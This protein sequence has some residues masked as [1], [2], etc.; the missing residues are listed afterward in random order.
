HVVFVPANDSEHC[1]QALQQLSVETWCGRFLGGM[2][3]WLRTH[4]PRFDTVMVCRHYVA[5]EMLP[6]VRRYAPQARLVFDTV[7]LH[8]LR[9]QRAAEVSGDAAAERTARTTRT[10]ELDIVARSD[11]TL[12]VSEV[13]REL[14]PT[15][16]PD[17]AV[18]IIS[19][20]HEPVPGGR[21]FNER[22]G[23]LFVGGF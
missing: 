19:N 14:L 17:A 11:V 10:L 3:G 13:E 6:L 4:G 18:E 12:V 22:A 20:L 2:P 9:E 8:Y 5:R 15:E 23:I 21:D 16:V 7:D 1:I